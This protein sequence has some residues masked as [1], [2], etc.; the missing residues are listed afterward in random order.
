[1][2]TPLDG[3]PQA[4]LGEEFLAWLWWRAETGRGSHRLAD[5]TEVGAVVDDLLHLRAPDGEGDQTLRRG[6][7]G[8]SAEAAAAL[9]A[10]KRPVRARLVLGTSRGEWSLTLDA[11]GFTLGAVKAPA[12]D[13]ELEPAEREA[14]LLRGAFELTALLDGLFANFLAERLAPGSAKDFGRRL[15][16]WAAGRVRRTEAGAPAAGSEQLD[17]QVEMPA[18]EGG[19]ET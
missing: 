5:G 12:P 17:E 9:A 2:R 16:A 13:P 19:V 7:P 4:F 6:L 14:E 3:D 11:R 18:Q 1:M 10:G 15:A 8:R